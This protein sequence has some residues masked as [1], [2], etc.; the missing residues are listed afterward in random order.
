VGA[1]V[2]ISLPVIGLEF[3]VNIVEPAPENSW[4]FAT[5]FSK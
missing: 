5:N 2:K 3:T 1:D 4:F